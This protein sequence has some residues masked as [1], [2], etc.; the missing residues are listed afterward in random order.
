MKLEMIKRIFAYLDEWILN[1]LS[2][3]LAIMPLRWIKFIAAYFPDARIRK[4]YW[5][6]LGVTLGEN[7]FANLG[8]LVVKNNSDQCRIVIGNNVSIAPHVTIITDSSPNNSEF[9]R[10]IEYVQQKLI[11]QKPVIIEDDVWI[12][13]GVVILPGV[14]VGR[15]AIIGAGSLVLKDVPMFTI[16]AGVP[17]RFLRKLEMNEPQVESQIQIRWS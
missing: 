9:L 11:C 14:H 2:N 15:G 4:L 13:A 7:S 3:N 16:V 17:A 12:G 8:F 1:F 5:G 6:T 10:G